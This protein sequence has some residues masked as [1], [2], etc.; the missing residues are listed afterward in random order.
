MEGVSVSIHP[1]FQIISE[2]YIMFFSKNLFKAEY[3]TFDY[4]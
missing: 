2:K 4:L 1:L 3:M